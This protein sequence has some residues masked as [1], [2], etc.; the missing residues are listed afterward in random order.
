MFAQKGNSVD[1]VQPFYEVSQAKK[2]DL[3]NEVKQLLQSKSELKA[4]LKSLIKFAKH[5]AELNKLNSQSILKSISNA[6][7]IL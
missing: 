3:E 7:K 1:Y 4:E 5:I 6:E 2:K